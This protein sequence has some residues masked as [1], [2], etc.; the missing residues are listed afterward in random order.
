M[1]TIDFKI[2][3]STVYGE[4]RG[5]ERDQEV[6]FLEAHTPAI[7][8]VIRIVQRQFFIF[9]HRSVMFWSTRWKEVF[10]V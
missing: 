10:S 4:K 8:P 5:K 6:L 9:H 2:K 3:T 1:V 7:Q